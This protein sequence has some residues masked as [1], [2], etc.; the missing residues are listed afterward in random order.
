MYG[1]GMYWSGVAQFGLLVAGS[2]FF[3]ACGA[4]TYLAWTGLYKSVRHRHF[5]E[6]GEAGHGHCHEEGHSH[7]HEEHVHHEHT[8]Q[9]EE[10]KDAH[11]D[12]TFL[13]EHIIYDPADCA[14][15]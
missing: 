11:E 14:I 6:E 9:M 15:L 12:G 8:L 7:G 5:E 10:M 1:S 2:S 4:A 13:H 3:V